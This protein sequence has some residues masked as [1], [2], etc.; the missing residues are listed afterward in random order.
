MSGRT[1][2]RFFDGLLPRKLSRAFA[3][4]I[5]PGTDQRRIGSLTPVDMARAV[6]LLKGLPMC[7]VGTGG[8]ESAQAT[9]GGIPLSEIDV[10][11][12]ESRLC[13]GL[14]LTGELLDAVGLCGGFNLQFAWACGHRAGQAAATMLCG[15]VF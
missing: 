6:A 2:D 10:S 12:M 1:Q 14:F 5:F 8:W 4:T 15:E 11:T 9:A 3:A 7:I 13:R